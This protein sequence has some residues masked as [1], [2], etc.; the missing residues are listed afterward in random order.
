MKTQKNLT[1]YD[2]IFDLAELESH[3]RCERKCFTE[4]V[5]IK[6]DTVYMSKPLQIFYNLTIRARIVTINY[7]LSMVIRKDQF[8]LLKT[9]FMEEN[10]IVFRN[11]LTMRHRK[12]GLIEIFDVK[13]QN[14]SRK[15]DK[16]TE[17]V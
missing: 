13:S 8:K 14:I 9:T 12:Y 15:I 2:T 4:Q 11:N 3:T 5:V 17:N 6:A 7:P 16:L 1:I 10:L